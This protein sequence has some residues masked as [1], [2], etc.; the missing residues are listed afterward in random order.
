MA[1]SAQIAGLVQTAESVQTAGSVWVVQTAG[2]EVQEARSAWE[3]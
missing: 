2:S 1:G 3:A